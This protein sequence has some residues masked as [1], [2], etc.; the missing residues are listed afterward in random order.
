MRPTS[1][2]RSLT[3]TA[4][5]LLAVA[6]ATAGIGWDAQGASTTAT[7]RT[8]TTATARAGVTAPRADAPDSIGWDATTAVV[9]GV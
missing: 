5:L 8:S 4:A 2:A 7:A 6:G 3:A 9:V 1:L